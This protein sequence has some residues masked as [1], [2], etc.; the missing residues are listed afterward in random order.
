MVPGAG[1]HALGPQRL[2]R[3]DDDESGRGGAAERGD[4]IGEIG[5]GAERDRRLRQPQA[6]RPHAHL[7]RRLL[8]GEIDD[9]GAGLGELGGRLEQ[10]RRFADARLAADQDGGARDEAAA[11]H[12]V[13]LGD[14]GRQARGF[15]GGGG[16]GFEGG[17]PAFAALDGDQ[18]RG[19]GR[20]SLLD[21]GVPL[22]AGGA[23]AGPAGGHRTAGLADEGARSFGH[24]QASRRDSAG[25]RGGRDG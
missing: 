22:A 18:G 11:E 23:F 9:P 20:G 24:G 25:R 1:F 15:M 16:E 10:Q 4:D 8:A 3:V 6:R 17:Q 7:G 19:A 5:L 12:A 2:H 21:D 14:A 13:K